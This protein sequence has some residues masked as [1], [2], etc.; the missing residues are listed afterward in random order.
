[1]RFAPF[2]FRLAKMVPFAVIS[3][4][5]ILSTVGVF[6]GGLWA[7]G[8]IAL[9][10]ALASF[11]VIARRRF[12]APN[13]ELTFLA[14]TALGLMALSSLWSLDPHTSLRESL[15]LAT[16]FLP[17][18]LLTIPDVKDEAA[19]DFLFPVL[20]MAMA[21]GAVAL[22][23]ELKLGG[24]LQKA[25]HHGQTEL[26]KYNRGLTYAILLAFPIMAWIRTR[27]TGFKQREIALA[28]FVVALLFPASL[29]ESRAGKLALVAGLAVTLAASLGPKL[30]SRTLMLL[31][32]LLAGWPYAAR[33]L[34]IAF[35]DK[36]VL[37]PPSW[38]H[39][40][41]IWD[42]MSWRVQEK[43]FLGWGIGT[44]PLLP[45]Q[46]PHGDLYEFAVIPA[47]HPH[48]AITQVWVELGIPGM[49]LGLLFAYWT[50]RKARGVS[51]ALVPFAFGSWIAALCL[52][53]TAYDF[54]TDSLF[55]AFALT[56]FAFSFLNRIP[57]SQGAGMDA[58]KT[59]LPKRRS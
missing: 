34:F 46:E 57:P 54:W 47:A 31:P 58:P 33:S 3:V 38:R 17:L 18:L 16:V 42:Y 9:A 29:T 8:G 2:R 40:M 49:A 30:V 21:V 1:M 52:S 26:T 27:S 14:F 36:L 50:L 10:L 35:H 39:R 24:A 6:S 15:R 28:L 41:E 37:L 59:H 7:I 13:P 12:S 20:A 51:P 48:N 45:F 19:A 32:V 53:L 22:G 4:Y 44:S 25:L 5:A 55:A 56:G 11:S 43:P 23:I